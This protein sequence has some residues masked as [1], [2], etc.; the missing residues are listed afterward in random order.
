MI[1]NTLVFILVTIFLSCK[2]DDTSTIY[3]NLNI[4]DVPTESLKI[5]SAKTLY[6]G[7]QSVGKNML[8]GVGEIITNDGRVK[9]EIV[10]TR[11]KND[12]SSPVFAHFYVGENTN[13]VGKINDFAVML[14]SGAGS[15]I[16]IAFM[17]LCY[18]D[19]DASTNVLDVFQSYVDAAKQI[20]KN[21]PETTL[22]HFTCPLTTVQSGIKAAIKRVIGRDVWGEKENIKRQEYNELMRDTF[23]GK[24]PLFDIAQ[25]ESTRID[26]SR[27]EASSNG[28]SY[29][30][31]ADEYTYDGGHLNETG[32]RI[33]AANFIRFIAAL[34]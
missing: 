25:I 13:P 5:L 14:N 8:D 32:R 17:K 18:L 15:E 1:K 19:F 31:L 34:D 21:N 11:S 2:S 27:L 10:E 33:V 12:L 6:F 23:V 26:G 16:D 20:Q 3:S 4:D 29:Y 22:V 24:E 28:V 7:H 30:Y 9:V